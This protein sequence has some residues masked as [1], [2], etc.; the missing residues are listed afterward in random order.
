M[1]E[2]INQPADV[3]ETTES[4]PI[5]ETAENTTPLTPAGQ[6]NALISRRN[7]EFEVKM[8]HADVKSIKNAINQKIEWKGPNEAYLVIMTVLT[9]DSVLEGMNPKEALPVKIKMPAATIE[10]INFFLTK[11]TGKGLD[12]AQRLFSTAMQLRQTVEAIRKLDEEIEVLKKEVDAASD[13]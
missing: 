2:T 12:S 4:A 9:L 11:I 1:E 6:L 13:K 3:L 10:S 5:Q 7:G 8:S